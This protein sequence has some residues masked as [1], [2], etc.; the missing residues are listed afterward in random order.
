MIGNSTEDAVFHLLR[1][2][3]RA[4]YTKTPDQKQ[5][6]VNKW[7][8]LLFLGT[9]RDPEQDADGSFAQGKA[10]L[11]AFLGAYSGAVVNAARLNDAG[12][13]DLFDRKYFVQEVNPADL[14]INAI[15]AAIVGVNKQAQLLELT[16]DDKTSLKFFCHYARCYRAHPQTAEAF[17]HVVNNVVDALNDGKLELIP[18]FKKY[19]IDLSTDGQAS[20]TVLPANL[21]KL[22]QSPW[23][24][25]KRGGA[26][27]EGDGKAGTGPLS[28]D[29][30]EK[31]LQYK[32]TWPVVQ[33]LGASN[34]P[35]PF[36][37]VLA[38]LDIRITTG[39]VIAGR[40]KTAINTYV[41][42]GGLNVTTVPENCALQISAHMRYAVMARK[43]E[44][45]A[46]LPDAIAI[47]YR[48]GL[49]TRFMRTDHKTRTAYAQGGLVDKSG[50]IAM[51]VPP[52]WLP[53]GT[54]LEVLGQ[55][56]PELV[57]HDQMAEPDYP[58]APLYRTF[59]G[60]FGIQDTH[61]WSPDYI[62]NPQ[63]RI[64]TLFPGAYRKFDGLNSWK[65]EKGV[66]P[67]GE[68]MRACN[69][70]VLS[71]RGMTGRNLQGNP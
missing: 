40:K 69:F 46:I 44:Q 21:A 45:L 33:W 18:E 51:I 49:S 47:E 52:A 55:P 71:G 42:D 50:L 27:A 6:F 11:R 48:G 58:T 35:L 56:H 65:M 3:A 43:P 12:V 59:Y 38:Q 10:D 17:S 53:T 54:I 39:A 15:L 34:F 5:D 2:L 8:P 4:F 23:A 63:G 67:L 64:G 19:G 61:I 25:P 36:G 32:L 26:G 60:D 20:A 57:T 13:G 24:K 9:S 66:G 68:E 28:I 30:V 31:R 1:T 29:Q 37:C 14:G 62:L 22:F 7:A 41:E 70:S 16:G